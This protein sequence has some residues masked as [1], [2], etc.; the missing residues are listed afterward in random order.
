IFKI[1]FFPKFKS[2]TFKILW[3]SNAILDELES[4]A[5][6]INTDTTPVVTLE[7]ATDA[8]RVAYQIIDCFDK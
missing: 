1:F 7:Q 6:A 2:I 5:N 3:Q 4:F 8:L